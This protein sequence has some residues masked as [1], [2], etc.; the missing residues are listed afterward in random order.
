MTKRV[1]YC[2][3]LLPVVRSAN[4]H[5]RARARTHT[6]TGFLAAAAVIAQKNLKRKARVPSGGQQE[7]HVPL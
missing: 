3:L 5:Q 6:L 2:F 4:L 1:L 7:P